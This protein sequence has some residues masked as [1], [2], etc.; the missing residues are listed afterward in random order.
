MFLAILS[1]ISLA[2]GSSMTVS[3]IRDARIG[4]AQEPT[5]VVEIAAIQTLPAGSAGELDP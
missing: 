2:V 3:D 4:A 1:A 5:A